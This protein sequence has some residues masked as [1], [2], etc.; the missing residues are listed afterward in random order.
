MV[1]TFGPAANLSCAVSGMM[2]AHLRL[3]EKDDMGTAST[4]RRIWRI[5]AVII[6]LVGIGLLA[7][8][9]MAFAAMAKDFLLGKHVGET[10]AV[11][12]GNEGPAHWLGE[13]SSLQGHSWSIVPLRSPGESGY[14]SKESSVGRNY[15]FVHPE[16]KSRWLYEGNER[17]LADP[18]LLP[19]QDEG[20][21]SRPDVRLVSFAVTEK[22]SD[23]DGEIT[24]RDL[25]SLVFTLPDG[26]RR[27]TV[28]QGLKSVVSQR[29]VGEQILVLSQRNDGYYLTVLQLPAYAVLRDER[30]QLP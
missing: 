27:T 5:N 2:P 22:D 24:G 15:L 14:L 18:V 13:P 30:I 21:G 23:G 7:L 11:G 6:L 10:V 28:L 26:S 4:F 3:P 9:A 19:Q 1:P 12:V 25:L 16:Q 8:I 29:L 17:L 20:D